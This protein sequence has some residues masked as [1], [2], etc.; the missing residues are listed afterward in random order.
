MIQFNDRE[1]KIICAA[2]LI[3]VG[4]ACFAAFYLT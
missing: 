4:A 2:W 3:I 1:M